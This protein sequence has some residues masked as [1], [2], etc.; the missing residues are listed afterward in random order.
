MVDDLG[1]P[2]MSFWEVLTIVNQDDIVEAFI[3]N[4]VLVNVDTIDA[5]N[6]VG[7]EGNTFFLWT[8]SKKR[9][10]HQE[11]NPIK[12]SPC[13]LGQRCSSKKEI[14]RGGRHTTNSR[15]NIQ[16]NK[17]HNF[18]KFD[19]KRSNLPAFFFAA[20]ATFVINDGDFVMEDVVFIV[21]DFLKLET[22]SS[23]PPKISF[24]TFCKKRFFLTPLR[25]KI[26][27]ATARKDHFCQ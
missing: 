12:W 15:N 8:L 2:R 19:W 18:V 13:Q 17:N 22:P 10:Q 5:T 23:Q 9:L 14:K 24:L 25:E 7:E 26:F 21:C 27:C 11:N 20:A 1:L 3:N 16:Y 6:M 4:K